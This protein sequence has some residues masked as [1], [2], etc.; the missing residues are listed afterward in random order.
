MLE[1]NAS[2]S[3]KGVF[4]RSTRPGK[5]MA[6]GIEIEDGA[7]GSL[8]SALGL[9]VQP[10]ARGQRSATLRQGALT[11]LDPRI[12]L[13]RFKQKRKGNHQCTISN[14]FVFALLQLSRSDLC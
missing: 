8:F 9:I 14:V 11:R 1:F 13:R 6:I 4:V 3:E 5:N 2:A 10:L 12:E 7:P